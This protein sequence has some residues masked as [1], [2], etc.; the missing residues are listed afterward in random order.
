LL[1][2]KGI[3]PTDANAYIM[4]QQG[5]GGGKALLTAPPEV[6]AVAALTPV[7]GDEKTG[8]ARPS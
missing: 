1:Q 3:E 6:G 5:A 7:Y 8:C 4:H 2:S